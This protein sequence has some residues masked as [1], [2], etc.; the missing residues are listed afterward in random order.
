MRAEIELLALEA[1]DAGKVYTVY[2]EGFQKAHEFSAKEIDLIAE[3][4]EAGKDYI[5]AIKEALEESGIEGVKV[6]TEEAHLEDLQAMS[7]NLEAVDE[8]I[9][10]ISDIM[11]QYAD[12]KINSIQKATKAKLTA[13]DK[14]EAEE[15]DADREEADKEAQAAVDAQKAEDEAEAEAEAE[16]TKACEKE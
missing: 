9:S 7:D 12:M 14:E 3:K 1:E 4:M 16:S 2:G 11:G 8:W 10:G 5:T 15:K 13:I 6:F